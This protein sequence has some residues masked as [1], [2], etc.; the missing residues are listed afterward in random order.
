MC[1]SILK[2]NLVGNVSMDQLEYIAPCSIKI[3][4]NQAALHGIEIVKQ[5]QEKYSTSSCEVQLNLRLK[6]QEE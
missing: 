1:M 4:N 2:T 6:E 5:Q 3:S